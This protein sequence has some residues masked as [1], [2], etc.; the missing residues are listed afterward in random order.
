[1]TSA[2]AAHNN[3]CIYDAVTIAVQLAVMLMRGKHANCPI[4]EESSLLSYNID[5]KQTLIS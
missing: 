3:Q 1:M 2:N 4:Y 5:T